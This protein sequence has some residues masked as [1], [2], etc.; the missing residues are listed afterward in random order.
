MSATI[1]NEADS[2]DLEALFD[3]IVE[4]NAAATAPAWICWLP[5]PFWG[6]G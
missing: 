1:D 2:P 3:S 5:G 6:W 4:A